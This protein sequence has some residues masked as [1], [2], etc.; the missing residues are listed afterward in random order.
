[1][2]KSETFQYFRD[3]QEEFWRL[4]KYGENL[5][6]WWYIEGILDVLEGREDHFLKIAF[7]S[8]DP[9]L[10]KTYRQGYGDYKDFK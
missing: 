3:L 7:Q 10:I 5:R 6:D 8:Y 1:M 9:Q 2:N 4:D